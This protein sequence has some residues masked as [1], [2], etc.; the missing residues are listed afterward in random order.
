M[1]MPKLTERA[2]SR[3]AEGAPALMISIRELASI[4]K[5]STRH[6]ERLDCVARI[7]EPIRFGRAKRWLLSDIN[8]WIAAGCPDRD[9]WQSMKEV[10]S[11]N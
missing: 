8:A 3:G 7:P 4:L 10:S 5:L 11:D 9:S 6:L 1:I 2:P